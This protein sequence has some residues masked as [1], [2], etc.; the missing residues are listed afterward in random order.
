MSEVF[1]FSFKDLVDGDPHAKKWTRVFTENG[2]IILSQ[3][4]AE[5]RQVS[6]SDFCQRLKDQKFSA[7]FIDNIRAKVSLS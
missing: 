3:E 6:V 7:D 1:L 2:L 5:D 4:Y